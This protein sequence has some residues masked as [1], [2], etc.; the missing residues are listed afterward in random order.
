M[1]GGSIACAQQGVPKSKSNPW[2]NHSVSLL[3]PGR[4]G[5]ST[6]DRHP[7]LPPMEQGALGAGVGADIPYLWLCPWGCCL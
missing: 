1:A 5:S 4:V 7:H 6:A 3:V 2:H